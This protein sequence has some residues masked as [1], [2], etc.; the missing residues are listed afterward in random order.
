VRILAGRAN[1]VEQYRALL[2]TEQVTLDFT[3]GRHAVPA[4]PRK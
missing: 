2:G 4:P 1:L 3:P